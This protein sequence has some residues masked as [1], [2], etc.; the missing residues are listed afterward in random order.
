MSTPSTKSKRTTG[1]I[2]RDSASDVEIVTA[3][4]VTKA[5]LRAAAERINKSIDLI[6]GHQD[7]FEDATLEHRLCIGLEIAVAQQAFGMTRAEAGQLGGRPAETLPTVGTVIEKPPAATSNPLGFSNWIKK[8]TPELAR[9]TAQRYATAFRALG[10]PHA[11]ATPQ[12]IKAKIKDLYNHADKN[13]LPR[14]SLAAL[15]KQAPKLPKPEA[16]TVLVPKT[17]KQLK[18]EDAREFFAKWKEDF[19]EALTKGHLDHLDKKGLLDLQ[20]FTATV[21]DRIKAR[22][23]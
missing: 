19:D 6:K 11:E 17:S 8:E 2:P 12:R 22:L 3:A 13:G 15:V 4:E 7:A 18:L 23:K 1:I 5:D 9:Q 10:I 16:L 20:E 21:R 14:P